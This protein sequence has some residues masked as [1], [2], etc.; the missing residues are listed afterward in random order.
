VQQSDSTG[1]R[2]ASDPAAG[3]VSPDADWR[4]RLT[5]EQYR[6]AREGG[7]ERAFSGAYWN[8]KATG[9]YHCVCCGSELFSS[10]T[11]F[12]SGTGWPSF[13]KGV[14]DGAI[15][16]HT[17]RSHGMERTEIRCARCDAHLGHVFN[18]G[19]APTGQRFCVNSASLRFEAG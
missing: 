6:V 18:D 19:P 7:T 9:M 5:P 2:P 13:W 14:S 1:A 16:T 10:A 17:D 8:N 4:D 11:K 3:T 15:T 12:D